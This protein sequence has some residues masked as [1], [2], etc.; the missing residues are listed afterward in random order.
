[1]LYLIELVI[2]YYIAEPVIISALEEL[3]TPITL[4]ICE[5]DKDRY[6]AVC[7]EKSCS[8]PHPYRMQ[9]GL[10]IS[11]IPTLL[12]WS[13]GKVGARLVEKECYN[14]ELITQFINNIFPG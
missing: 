14:L 8:L 5:V 1:M 9:S 12:D 6:K 4:L 13:S 10:S 11:R 3:D 2:E 7:N